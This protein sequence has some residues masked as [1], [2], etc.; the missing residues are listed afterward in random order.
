MLHLTAD[1][2]PPSW[3]R[4]EVRALRPIHASSH[5]ARTSQN[6]GSIQK[7]V[8]LLIPG[9]T[10]DTLAL[11]PL[12]CPRTR[13]RI[14]IA[15]HVHP[16]HPRSRASE[17]RPQVAVVVRRCTPQ[18]L[19]ESWAPL[20]FPCPLSVFF[21]PLPPRVSPAPLLV[22][23]PLRMR[24]RVRARVRRGPRSRRRG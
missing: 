1:A 21:F 18:A 14:A 16:H 22:P 8:V 5:R 11:P 24:L 4:V 2:P 19:D 23:V 12:P 10:P 13:A 7:V 15:V 9:I 17:N 20:P 3:V 6:P